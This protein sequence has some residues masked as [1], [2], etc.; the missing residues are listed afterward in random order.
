MRDKFVYRIFAASGEL[1]YVGSTAAPDTRMAAHRNNSV[2]FSAE[3]RVVIDGP[4]KGSSADFIEGMAIRCEKPKHNKNGRQ[5]AQ[6]P[7]LDLTPPL[8]LNARLHE[9]ARPRAEYVFGL[10]ASGETW[11]TI[12]KL[13]GITRQCAQQLAARHAPPSQVAA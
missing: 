5:C 4:H 9:A 1:L 8:S 11:A 10:R 3:C 2:W 7:S 13:L 12:G 6:F